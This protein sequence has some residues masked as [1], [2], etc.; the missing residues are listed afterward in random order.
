M[1]LGAFMYPAGHHV[2]AWRHPDVAAD[3]T[4]NLRQRIAFARAAEAAKFDLLFLADG[5]STHTADLTA[6]RRADEWAIGFEPL[7][8]LSALAAVTERIGLVATVSTTF[9][10]PF[11]LARAFASLDLISGGRAGWNLVTSSNPLE[12]A[13]FGNVSAFGHSDR[14]GRAEEFVDVV[15]GLWSSWD[16]DAF[17]RDKASGIF[18]DAGKLRV[19]DHRGVHFRVRGPLTVPRSAQGHPVVVQA[20]SS[21]PGKE[22][23]ARTA[24]VVF[25]AQRS[26]ADAQAFYADLK[27]RLPSYGRTADSLKVMPGIFPVVGRSTAEAEDKFAALQ[28]LIHP[29][30][31]LSLLANLSGGLDL[32]AYPLDGPLPELPVTEGGRSRQELVLALARRDNLTIRQLYETIAGARGHWQLVGTGPQI[33]DR[34]EEWFLGHGADGFNVMPPIVPSGLDDFVQLVLP[35]LRRRGLARSEYAG[36]TLRAQLGLQHPHTQ[37]RPGKVRPQPETHR[38]PDTHIGHPPAPL[39]VRPVAGRVGAEIAGVTLSGDLPEAT[40]EAINAALL[41]HKVIFFRDQ[42]HLT[43]AE[44]ER[45]SARLG[46]LVPHPTQP[47]R[48]GTSSVLE[49]DSRTGYGRADAWHTD[50]TF[51]AAYPKI[52]VLRGVIVPKAGG[53]TVW[54]NTAAAYNSL[55][56]DLKALAETLWAVH[57]NAYDYA[58]AKPDASEEARR[59]HDEVFASTAYETEHPV[60]RVHPETGERT[61]ILGSFVQRFVGHSKRESERLYDLLQSYVQRI[62]NTVRWRWREGDVAIWDNRATQHIAVND[63]G[64]QP[65]V[66]RRTTIDGD[67]PVSVDGRHSVTVKQVVR[68]SARA[69]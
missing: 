62:E 8:L 12:A 28:S 7:T 60:V 46:D 10:E 52:S 63:Y 30:V 17:V 34:L 43:D 53:D 58:A 31:G 41:R 19:L 29:D 64:D 48:D 5:V 33:A 45:F 44:Q 21:E 49:L 69:G 23:A 40:V 57:T 55:P 27:S 39:D 15:R 36:P 1:A 59:H 25:T 6:L 20:G 50:V 22:L 9:N 54:S 42:T 37:G 4:T 2:A 61:L 18:F 24:E 38:M 51:V 65:R 32:S 66:V 26:L 14:Y 67:V 3:A 11:T 16:D 68:H 35:E 13:N 47:V 56:A